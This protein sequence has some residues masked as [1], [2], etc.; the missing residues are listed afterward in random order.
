MLPTLAEKQVLIVD[1]FFYKLIGLKK[2]DIIIA[3]SPVKYFF[4]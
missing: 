1:K 4:Y 2:G 3:H